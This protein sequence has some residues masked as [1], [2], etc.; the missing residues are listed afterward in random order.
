[1]V[2]VVIKGN[3]FLRSYEERYDID[4]YI[5]DKVYDNLERPMYG[6]R[7]PEGVVQTDKYYEQELQLKKGQ[8]CHKYYKNN[9]H[10]IKF[11]CAAEQN[12]RSLSFSR[13]CL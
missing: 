3:P 7:T 6:L 1:M 5:I 4:Y 11:Q 10:T 2:R 12:S 9:L 13:Q 8:F